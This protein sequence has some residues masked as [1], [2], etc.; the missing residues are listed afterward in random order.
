[1][2]YKED[3]IMRKVFETFRGVFQYVIIEILFAII[4][5]AFIEPI[6]F[7]ESNFS[8][9]LTSIIIFILVII[10]LIVLIYLNFRNKKNKNK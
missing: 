2:M 4:L 9:V 3:D 5:L 10:F 1:M 6:I 7:N 8:N